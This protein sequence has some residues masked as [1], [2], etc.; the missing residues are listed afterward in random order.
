MV[1]MLYYVV[2]ESEF[3]KAQDAR[4]VSHRH[5]NLKKPRYSHK[6]EK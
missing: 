6:L 5:A 4:Y 2:A 1:S 3:A